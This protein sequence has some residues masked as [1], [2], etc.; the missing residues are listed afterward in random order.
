[1]LALL[2]PYRDVGNQFRAAE[3]EYTATVQAM[4]EWARPE[5]GTPVKI[6]L[7]LLAWTRKEL[8]HRSCRDI[9]FVCLLLQSHV[10]QT[11]ALKR[12]TG[13]F[14]PFE[15]RKYLHPL[16]VPRL[17]LNRGNSLVQDAPYSIADGAFRD[18]SKPT[19]ILP[20]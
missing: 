10:L 9:P 15:K 17:Y 7:C 19:A 3:A 18:R 8:A 4:P 20:A 14:I 6:G 1:M 11:N 12:Q 13:K 2:A 5:D 16:E